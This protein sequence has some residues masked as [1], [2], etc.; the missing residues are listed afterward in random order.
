MKNIKYIIISAGLLLFLSGV[1]NAQVL[2]DNSNKQGKINNKGTIRIRTT[3]SLL[4]MPDTIGGRVEFVDN[5]PEYEQIIPNICYNVLK[6]SGRTNRYVDSTWANKATRQLSVLDSLILSDSAKVRANAVEVHAKGVVKNTAVIVGKEDVRLNQELNSQV[7]TG[8]G[9][10]SR[11]NIDNPNGVDI[12]DGGG[13]TVQ[14]KLELTRG[15]FRNSSASNFNMGDAGLQRDGSTRLDTITVSYTAECDSN[16]MDTVVIYDTSNYD[17]SRPLIVRHVGASLSMEPNFI[18][19]TVD[20]RYTGGGSMATTGEVPSNPN[21]LHDLYVENTDSLIMARAVTV[22]DSIYAATHIHTMNDT[23]TLTSKKNPHYEPANPNAEIYGSFRRT[24]WAEGERILLNNPYTYLLFNN[25]VNRSEI[26]TITSSIYPHQYHALKNGDRQKVER[27]ITLAAKDAAGNDNTNAIDAEFGYGWR[28]GGLYDETGSLAFDK[29]RLQFFQQSD[30][31][32]VINATSGTPVN[33]PDGNWGYS[34]AAKITDFG[35]YAIGT[36]WD[37]IVM[38]LKARLEGAYRY[39]KK[40][41][42]NELQQKG[43]IPMPPPDTYPYNIDKNRAFY[44]RTDGKLPDSVVDWV[45]VVFKESYTSENTIVNTLLLKTDGSLVDM[46]GNAQVMFST[47]GEVVYSNGQIILPQD[48]TKSLIDRDY[49]IAVMHRNHTAVISTKPEEFLIAGENS[50]DF[51]RPSFVMGGEHS[52]R[53]VDREPNAPTMFLYG[54]IA[55][56]V[57]NGNMPDGIITESDYKA[58]LPAYSQWRNS[59]FEGYLLHDLDLN[60]IITTRDYNV[61]FNNRNKTTLFPY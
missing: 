48:T 1:I 32:W 12:V 9:H 8:S 56:D 22:N 16:R 37:Y 30:E 11:L 57:N 18:E 38:S 29:L 31:N 25:P 36:M 53:K 52:L 61:G 4:G 35:Y 43:L 44:V 20:I 59:V 23:L 33:N 7:I 3:G 15:E 54:M 26:S 5:H 10:F 40:T 47:T 17:L 51:T 27:A 50:F 34:Q 19:N 60:G 42:G 46:Y 6:I 14:N 55:G 49:Y 28:Y 39:D 21:V 45:V 13:F 2:I 58:I 41:M 24:D